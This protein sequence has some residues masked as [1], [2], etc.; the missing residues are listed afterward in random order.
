[1]DA[2]FGQ[3][4]ATQAAL[5]PV[6]HVATPNA[7]NWLILHVDGRPDARKQSKALGDALTAN[8]ARVSVLSVP[9]SSHSSVNKD[10]GTADTFTGDAIAKFL[11]QPR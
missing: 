5:S 7:K 10:A 1:Y 4:P 6:T 2:A 11:D 3:D 9:N 8:G